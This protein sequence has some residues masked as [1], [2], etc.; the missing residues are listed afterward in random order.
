MVTKNVL[1]HVFKNRKKS[2]KPTGTDFTIK[3]L[4]ANENSIS[5]TSPLLD[6]NKIA[7]ESHEQ[8]FAEEFS[9]PGRSGGGLL[10]KLSGKYIALVGKI[11]VPC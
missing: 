7:W 6:K 10:R 8:A 5:P 11:L 3:N 2:N 4:I 9:E 1:K